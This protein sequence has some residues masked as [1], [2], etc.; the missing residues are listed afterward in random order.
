MSI[1]VRYK[2]WPGG[3]PLRKCNRYAACF[4][5]ALPEDVLVL[6]Q[7]VTV[8]DFKIGFE[9]K[10]TFHYMQIY[11]RSSLLIKYGI[12]MPTSIIDTDYRGPIHAIMYNTKPYDIGLKAGMRIAQVNMC[13]EIDAKFERVDELN[14][15][16]RGAK[17]LGSTGV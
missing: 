16:D 6:A 14:E 17:G 3:I 10:D 11:P 13:K 1:E 5:L 8:A 7:S 2:L 4:D 9:P 12:I 15:T